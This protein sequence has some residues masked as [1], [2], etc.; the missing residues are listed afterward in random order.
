MAGSWDDYWVER[1]ASLWPSWD[2]LLCPFEGLRLI[3]WVPKWRERGVRRVLVA[4]CGITLVHHALAHCGFEAVALDVSATAI[5]FLRTRSPTDAQLR[6]F[7]QLDE[8][9]NARSVFDEYR[10]PGGSATLVQG[11]F[12]DARCAPGPFDLIA[13]WRCVQHLDGDPLTRA[14]EALDDRTGGN[15]IWDFS[16]QNDPA[17]LKHVTRV[18]EAR[19]YAI[20]PEIWPRRRFLIGGIASG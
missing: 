16:V 20:N 8:Q 15:G 11:D 18:L 5:E 9:G 19:G 14:V 2:P 13:A 10:A 12:L 3:Q 17:R 1:I 4:G 6:F 7:F